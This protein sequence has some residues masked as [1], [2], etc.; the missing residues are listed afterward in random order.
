[1]LV[2]LC[3]S[4]LNGYAYDMF[5]RRICIVVS[6]LGMSTA[7]ILIPY[8]APS[9]VALTFVRILLGYFSHVIS[10]NPLLIDYV[11]SDSRGRATSL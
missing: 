4:V 8:S 1:M 2:T 11:K 7:M 6:I 10:S 9:L 5:G 3:M